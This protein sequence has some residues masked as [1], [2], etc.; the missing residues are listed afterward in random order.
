MDLRPVVLKQGHVYPHW[1]LKTLS[2]VWDFKMI[3]VV[4]CN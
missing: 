2:G 1:H 3:I 4:W